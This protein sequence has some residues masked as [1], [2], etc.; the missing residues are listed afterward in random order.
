MLNHILPNSKPPCLA[1]QNIWCTATPAIASGHC[2]GAAAFPHRAGDA[3]ETDFASVA[4]GA[5]IAF[6]GPGRFFQVMECDE[7]DASGE[8]PRND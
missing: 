6:P 7:T 2:L 5:T 3:L 4:Q 1:G 8:V